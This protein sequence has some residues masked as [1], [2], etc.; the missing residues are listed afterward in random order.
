MVGMNKLVGRYS[1]VSAESRGGPRTLTA[2]LSAAARRFPNNIAVRY[3]PSALTYAELVACAERVATA[4]RAQG[5]GPDVRVGLCAER[6]LDLL[7]G[8]VGIL[9][10]GGAYVPLD[11]TYPAERLAFIIEDAGIQ[12][13]L[14]TPGGG[15]SLEA[16]G[17]GKLQVL[18]LS[19][20]PEISPDDDARHIRVGARRPLPG[21]AAYVIYTSG[22]TGVPKGVVVTHHNVCRLLRQTQ[23]WFQFGPT[24]VWTLFHSFAFDF[25]VWEIWGA[26][27]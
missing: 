12:V 16:C 13:V 3:G 7:I 17:S 24:D 14:A 6:G 19:A 1:A 9:K 4:L 23:D 25:S 18:D 22:S 26:L 2:L 11:P 21:D 5:V 10:A 15:A 27:A 20:L 8:L